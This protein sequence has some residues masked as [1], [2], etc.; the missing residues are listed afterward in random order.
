MVAVG[1]RLTRSDESSPQIP[2]LIHLV[3]ALDRE[4]TP[5]VNGST[6]L[7]LPQTWPPRSTP[8]RPL[9]GQSQQLFGAHLDGM[10]SS[11][12]QNRSAPM[13]LPP[14]TPEAQQ[15]SN[16]Q[17]GMR[18]NHHNGHHRVTLRLHVHHDL[19]TELCCA[20]R[21]LA[22]PIPLNQ[23]QMSGTSDCRSATGNR[24]LKWPLVVATGLQTKL[25]RKD[26]WP[27]R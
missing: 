12:R 13:R 2:K 20:I 10:G 17:I 5:F 9:A 15:S 8:C 19:S 26:E 4:G 27:Q 14:E 7:P 16:S 6:G 11:R 23:R 18:H 1:S 24:R 21:N 3:A 22:P 25:L